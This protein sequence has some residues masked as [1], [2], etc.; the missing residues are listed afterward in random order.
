[1]C[2]NRVCYKANLKKIKAVQQE[3]EGQKK[4]LLTFLES[5]EIL[6]CVRTNFYEIE[7]DKM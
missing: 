5:F 3:L 7:N 4:L 6:L 1:M 2:K